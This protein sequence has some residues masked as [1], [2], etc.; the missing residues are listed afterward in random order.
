MLTRRTGCTPAPLAL[1]T[2]LHTC[3]PLPWPK[4]AGKVLRGPGTPSPGSCRAASRTLTAAWPE[5]LHRGGP[6]CPL[7]NGSS[8]HPPHPPGVVAPR[9]QVDRAGASS[10]CVGA[11]LCSRLELAL[12]GGGSGQAVQLDYPPPP[13]PGPPD[14]APFISTIVQIRKLRRRHVKELAQSH[15]ASK[16]WAELEPSFGQVPA[17]T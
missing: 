16:L 4:G 11:P 12:A 1:Q 14:I 17:P 5:A 3:R 13:S 8:E 15:A 9:D 2:L 6:R 10:K 7:L